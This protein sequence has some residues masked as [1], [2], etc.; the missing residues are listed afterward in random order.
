MND[1]RY[2]A[3]ADAVAPRWHVVA[4]GGLCE[5]SVLDCPSETVA[6]SEARKMNAAL[7]QVVVVGDPLD[8]PIP[9]GFYGD[10]DGQGGLF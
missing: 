6:R 4:V 8:R 10:A 5:L 1:Q 9:A 3:M 2:V 7:P